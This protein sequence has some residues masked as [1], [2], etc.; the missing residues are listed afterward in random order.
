[1]SRAHDGTASRSAMAGSTAMT[2]HAWRGLRMLKTEDD[3][4]SLRQR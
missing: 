2:Y 1:M 4:G 3:P